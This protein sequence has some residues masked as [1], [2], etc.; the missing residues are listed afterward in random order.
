[1]DCLE[2]VDAIVIG[3][4]NGVCDDSG[5]PFGASA[6]LLAVL[7]IAWLVVVARAW[8]SPRVR[9]LALIAVGATAGARGGWA[10]ATQRADR[11]PAIA[12]PIQR[13][14]DQVRSFAIAHRGAVVRTSSCDA[15]QPIVR[16]ALVDAQGDAPIDLYPDALARGCR[17]ENDSL[18]CGGP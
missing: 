15:C 1:V 14:H 13:L 17:E 16:L 3:G 10:C 7:A 5:S 18:R 6:I 11:D 8:G 4:A 9:A 12:V 2:N